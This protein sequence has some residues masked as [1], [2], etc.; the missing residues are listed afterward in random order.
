M[1]LTSVQRNGSGWFKSRKKCNLKEV[2]QTLI[3]LTAN[4]KILQLEDEQNSQSETCCFRLKMFWFVSTLFWELRWQQ[5]NITQMGCDYLT[6][7]PAEMG[8]VGKSHGQFRACG[9][10]S[11][12]P[13]SSRMSSSACTTSSALQHGWT[14]LKW[15]YLQSD[16]FSNLILRADCLLCFQQVFKMVCCS[17]QTG[18]HHRPFWRVECGRI[19]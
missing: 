14:V 13:V 8:Q 6:G 17:L 11:L 10:H 9:R 15:F 19:V 3:E 2:I 4:I 16:P 5:H 18:L 7:P 12:I 1:T